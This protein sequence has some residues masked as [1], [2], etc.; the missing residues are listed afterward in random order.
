M[1]FFA[2]TVALSLLGSL[3]N[4]QS[5]ND[6][7]LGIVAIEAHFTNAQ[8]VPELLKTFTPSAVMNVTFS[9]VGAISPGQNLS[10]ER[11]SLSFFF[12]WKKRK[13]NGWLTVWNVDN[14]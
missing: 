10:R 2:T 8:L 7:A 4:A 3:V 5:A 1:L 9:G 6:A 11:Q 13:K 12:R 14:F